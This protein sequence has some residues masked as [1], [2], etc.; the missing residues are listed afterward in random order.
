M[1]YYRI[2]FRQ[3]PC[4]FKEVNEAEKKLTAAQRQFAA[5]NH[6]LIY[7]FLNAKRLPEDDFYDI[8]VFGY[9][10]A[11]RIYFEKPGLSSKY[12]FSTIA[13]NAM[14]TSISDY[15]QKQARL[16][17]QA[18]VIDFDNCEALPAQD[19][20]TM[21]FETELLMLELASKVSKR[22][23]EIMRMRVDGYGIREIAKAQKMP[24]KSVKELLAGLRETVLAVCYEQRG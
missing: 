10:H 7:T 24:V 11:V 21:D 1:G 17:R 20:Y 23:M 2:Y 8:A 15:Y 12:A 5:E 16:K 6:D 22:E 4:L 14:R 9:L 13:W 3:Y 18:I 19:S